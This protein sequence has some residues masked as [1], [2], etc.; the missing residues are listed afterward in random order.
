MREALFFFLSVSAAVTLWRLPKI[1]SSSTASDF[2]AARGSA[3]SE[4]RW[5]RPLALPLSPSV[6]AP[7]GGASFEHNDLPPQRPRPPP[8]C[9]P[10]CTPGCDPDLWAF[11]C[12]QCRCLKC[13]FCLSEPPT[14]PV[15][16]PPP[17]RGAALH[18]YSYEAEGEDEGEDASHRAKVAEVP[19]LD[20]EAP[21][22]RAEQKPL[23]HGSRGDKGK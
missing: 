8:G 16:P 20:A 21:A 1:F 19:D 15:L 3:Q 6:V 13:A 12:Q 5:R 9:D 4:S 23:A 2:S 7:S 11:H 10:D 14:P 22:N 18:R 17:A